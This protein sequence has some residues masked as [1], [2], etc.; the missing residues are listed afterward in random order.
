MEGSV[1]SGSVF[2]QMYWFI[3]T[4]SV[5]FFNIVSLGTMQES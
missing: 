1:F 5:L 2:T 3:N 4:T